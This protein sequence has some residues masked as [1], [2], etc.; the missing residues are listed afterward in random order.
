M[1]IDGARRATE[2]WEAALD[3]DLCMRRGDMPGYS[4][5]VARFNALVAPLR[6]HSHG[7]AQSRAAVRRLSETMDYPWLDSSA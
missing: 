5:A 2:L 4:T 7:Y 1:R 3:A 6:S